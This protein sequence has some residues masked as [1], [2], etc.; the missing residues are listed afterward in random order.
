MH[1]NYICRCKVP[2]H[3]ADF[4]F[5]TLTVHSSE[6]NYKDEIVYY[7]D[8]KTLMNWCHIGELMNHVSPITTD[9]VMI[10]R[11]NLQK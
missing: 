4:I 8:I 7:Y 2:A 9:P 5:F 11:N 3:G 6:V 10:A 1:T